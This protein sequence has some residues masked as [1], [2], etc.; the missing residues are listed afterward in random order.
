MMCTAIWYVL[1]NVEITGVVGFILGLMSTSI[2]LNLAGLALLLQQGEGS[3]VRIWATVGT[4]GVLLILF[5]AG[6]SILSGRRSWH[7]P[8]RNYQRVEL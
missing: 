2:C 3:V 8:Q 6:R 5:V 4:F 7:M 1:R